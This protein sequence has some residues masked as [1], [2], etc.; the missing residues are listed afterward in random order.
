MD[1][2]GH[3]GP[4]GAPPCPTCDDVLDGAVLALVDGPVLLGLA[5]AQLGDQL[6]LLLPLLLGLDLEQQRV[7]RISSMHSEVY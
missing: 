7:F 3:Q 4:G 5:A 1:D 6:V 2:H